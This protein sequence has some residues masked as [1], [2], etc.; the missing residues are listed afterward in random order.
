VVNEAAGAPNLAS[1][2]NQGAF[3]FGNASGAWIGGLAL[4]N[5][6]A[7]GEIPWIGA[8]LAALGLALSLFSHLLDRRKARAGDLACC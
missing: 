6:M 5:G 2:L 1:T 7:Y 8:A 3:N 4:T